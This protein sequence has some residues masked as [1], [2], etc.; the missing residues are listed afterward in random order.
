MGAAVAAPRVLLLRAAVG[1]QE[2]RASQTCEHFSTP[3]MWTA[4]VQF[5][6]GLGG[7]KQGGS[8]NRGSSGSMSAQSHC[9]CST[10]LLC[11]CAGAID[12]EELQYA[13][14]VMGIQ[15][16]AADVQELMDSVD[17]DG[18][19]ECQFVA[20]EQYVRSMACLSTATVPH[21][22]LLPEP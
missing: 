21:M 9:M 19:G 8:G 1:L 22:P 14:E 3:L 6:H 5:K 4:Q 10:A 15:K 17:K 13:L 16:S 12:V 20:T 2:A 11:G 7:H 18:S